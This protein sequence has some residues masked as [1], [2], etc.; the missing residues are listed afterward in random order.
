MN[1]R[2]LRPIGSLSQHKGAKIALYGP[3]GTGK[4]PMATQIERGCFFA[5]ERGL[6]S[7]IGSQMPGWA[8][9]FEADARTKVKQI[10]DFFSWWLGPPSNTSGLDTLIIDSVTQI[11]NLILEDCESRTS[12]G[13]KAYG[14]MMKDVLTLI[15]A[16]NNQV[17]KNIV[18]LCQ[19]QYEER[20][21]QQGLTTTQIKVAMPA[22]PGQKLPP[23]A[24]HDIDIILYAHKTSVPG[25]GETTALLTS[26][27]PY[28]QARDR[29]GT[30]DRL[31]PPNLN[32][33]IQ[34]INHRK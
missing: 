19:C 10:K 24:M 31:E 6:M 3:P 2:D 14:M 20:T 29:S 17:S 7:A 27:A 34:K 25:V 22:F 13:L 32:T 23:K 4:T 28:A 8:I 18:M 9:N 16:L 15:D 33:I 30:L 21:I 5:V 1:A 12:H 26:E 11:A